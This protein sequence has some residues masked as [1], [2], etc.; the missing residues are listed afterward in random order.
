MTQVIIVSKTQMSNTSCVG[1]LATNGRF[2]RLLNENGY[3]QPIDTDF[4]VRQVWEI[5]FQEKENRRPPHIEDVLVISKNLEGMIKDEFSML[6]MVERF[7]APIWRGSPDVLFD[8]KLNW[9]DNGSGYIS[10]NGEIPEHSVGFWIPD[11][12]LTKKIFYEKIR[13]NYPTIN[14]W[15]SLPYVGYAESVN[16]I[17]AGTLIRVSLARWWDRN[18]ETENRCSLQLSGWYNLSE[19]EQNQEIND[20]DL[21]F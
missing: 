13:Y 15:R 9:T 14:G 3:N 7:N 4:T 16:L 1:A 11:R 20:N 21:P 2:L 5:E 18:G 12:K 6:Q 10:E 19:P 17:Q 8:C